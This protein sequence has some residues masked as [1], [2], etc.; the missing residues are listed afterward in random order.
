M[1]T[2]LQNLFDFILP[3][4]CLLCGKIIKSTDSLCPDCFKQINFISEPYCRHCG[5]PLIGHIDD[6]KGLSCIECLS[7]KSLFRMCRAAI[8]YDEFSKKIILDFKFTDHLENRKLLA[9]WLYVAGKDIFELG[10]DLIIPVPLHYTRLFRR[11]YNQSAILATELSSLIKIPTDFKS[12]KKIRYTLPQ[13]QC[14]G[15]RRIVNIKNAFNVSKPE[16]V[17][18]KRI[19]LIDDVY[20]TG[21]TLKECAK[22]LLKAGAKSVDALTVARVCS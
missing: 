13:V 1:M 12:L 9:H 5:K 6:I 16:N 20:T 22:V 11:K 10:A 14:N 17:K 21:S 8:E 7:K 4:R 18:G 19:I 15:K 2:W 3:K